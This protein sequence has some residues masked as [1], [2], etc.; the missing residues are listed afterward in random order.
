MEEYLNNNKMGRDRLLFI[1]IAAAFIGI[2][3]IVKNTT[4]SPYFHDYPLIWALASV[5]LAKFLSVKF[6][7]LVNKKQD[8]EA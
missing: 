7:H 8:D 2:L 5:G 1:G 4:D 3:A 6:K